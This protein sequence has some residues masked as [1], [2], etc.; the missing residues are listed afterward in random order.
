MVTTTDSNLTV[1]SCLIS[2]RPA[3][4]IAMADTVAVG[5]PGFVDHRVSWGSPGRIASGP[6]AEHRPCHP[7]PEHTGLERDYLVPGG[8]WTE[9]MDEHHSVGRLGLGHVVRL[10][11]DRRLVALVQP[12]G[13][14][15]PRPYV[16][17]LPP[18]CVPSILFESP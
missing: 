14:A 12:D 11:S 9:E 1:V 5:R 3:F 10:D 18:S 17:S 13:L 7:E 8:R 4:V 6:S 16:H 2:H 15:H